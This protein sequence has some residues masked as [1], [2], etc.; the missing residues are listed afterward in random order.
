[1]N[2]WDQ[3]YLQ[4]AEHVSLWSK[5][6]STKT[7]AVIVTPHNE[8]VSVG[9]NGF[10]RG[11]ADTA[12]RLNNRDIK[13]RMI[14]H[15]ERNAMLFAARPLHGCTL[16]TVPFMSCADCAAMVVQAGIKRCVAPWSDNPRWIE[17]F[18]LTEALFREG[19]VALDL[20]SYQMGQLLKTPVAA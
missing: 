19:G 11:V 5:D 1:M 13:Y 7:G 20:V 10:P 9:F 3:R 14:V 15:C 18:K 4:L 16:Y 8:V 2:H 17:S 12:E 6:P